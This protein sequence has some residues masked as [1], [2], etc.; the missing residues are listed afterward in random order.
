[1]LLE[2]PILLLDDP[3]ASID[4]ETEHEI[5]EA[6]ES[7]IAGRTTFIVAHRLCTLRRADRVIVLEQGHIVQSGTH[8]ELMRLPGPYRRS[9]NIQAVDA[10]SMRLLREAAQRREDTDG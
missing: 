5:L 8:D 1:M 7:A 2:P 9:V 6:I 4:P 3:T 10:E